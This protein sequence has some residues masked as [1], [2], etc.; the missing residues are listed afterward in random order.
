MKKFLNDEFYNND[1]E[2]NKNN[3]FKYVDQSESKL[4]LLNYFMTY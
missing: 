2:H 1:Y 4:F 3:I